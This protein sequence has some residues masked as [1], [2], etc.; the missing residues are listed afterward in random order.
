M[1][2]RTTEAQ[3][4]ELAA[5]GMTWVE[6]AEVTGIPVVA[7]RVTARVLGISRVFKGPPRLRGTSKKDFVTT[8]VQRYRELRAAGATYKQIAEMT[9]EP[10]MTVYHRLQRRNAKDGVTA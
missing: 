3:L 1:T 6:I 8:E 9:G 4:R 10:M 2:A 7:I 5:E